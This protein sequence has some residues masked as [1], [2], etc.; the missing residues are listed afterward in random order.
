MNNGNERVRCG[1]TLQALEK[2]DPKLKRGDRPQVDCFNANRACI[3]R[4]AS[5]RFDMGY[6]EHDGTVMI[7]AENL[8]F[9][10]RT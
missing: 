7:K 5:A 2:L 8:W 4:A 1:I 3:E 6:V 10:W 9:I